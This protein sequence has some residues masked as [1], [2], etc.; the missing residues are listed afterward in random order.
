MKIA[1]IGLGLIGGSLGRTIVKKTGDEVYAFD[2]NSHAMIEGK[3]LSAYHKPLTK[4]NISIFA[5]YSNNYHTFVW[6]ICFTMK[7]EFEDIASRY[8]VT[9]ESLKAGYDR[10]NKKVIFK[11]E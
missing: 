1:I 10:D 3:L 7:I 9:V 2:I 11:I 8:G 5:N 4:E 6:L